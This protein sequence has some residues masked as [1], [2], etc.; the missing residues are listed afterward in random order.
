MFGRPNAPKEW[1]PNSEFRNQEEVEPTDSAKSA[2]DATG[3]KLKR[4]PLGFLRGASLWL[5]MGF[6]FRIGKKRTR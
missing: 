3:L 1:E 2:H 6:R 5:G 4:G